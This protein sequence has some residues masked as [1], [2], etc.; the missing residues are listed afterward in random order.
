MH[1]TVSGIAHKAFPNDIEAIA[2]TRK[3]LS[4]LPQSCYEKR[5]DK[6][7]TDFDRASQASC[8]IL[9]NVI[10]TEDNLPYDM[11]I[12]LEAVSDRNEIFEI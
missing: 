12:V 1:S 9:D 8:N 5:G 11:K 3:L 10:P 2:N 4:Y 6:P 7:W